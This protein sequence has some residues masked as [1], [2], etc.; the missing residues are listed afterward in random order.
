MKIYDRKIVRHKLSN[1]EGRVR[2]SLKYNRLWD[3]ILESSTKREK[4]ADCEEYEVQRTYAQEWK[5]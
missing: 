1:M 5:Y 3:I 4:E 2:F